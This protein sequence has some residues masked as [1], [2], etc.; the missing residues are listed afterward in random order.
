MSLITCGPWPQ[1]PTWTLKRRR[2]P[3]RELVA[4][5][6]YVLRLNHGGAP[7][8][9]LRPA[10]VAGDVAWPP[11]ISRVPAD[12]VALWRDLADLTNHPAA[13]A[14]FS[15]LLF[16][17]RDGA[18]RDWAAGRLAGVTAA[19]LRGTATALRLLAGRLDP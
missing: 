12:V 19:V 6:S 11:A 13:R 18:D 15:D 8:C 16:E 17:R 1:A 14:R 10:T 4:A 2:T 9:E 5:V 7:T 3:A